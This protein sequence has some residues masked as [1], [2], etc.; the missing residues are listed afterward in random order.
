MRRLLLAVLA[1][2]LA[3]PAS[4]H[5]AE[6]IMA[7]GEVQVG[8]RCTGLTVFRG[9]D[10]SS[11]DVEVL[12]VIG[13]E[14]PASARLLVRVSGPAIDG[15]GVGPGFSGSPILCPGADGVARTIGAISETIGEFGG[16][17]VLA[18][19]IESILSQPPLPESAQP[20]IPGARSLA[21]PLTIAGL[22][23][24]LATS[25]SRAASKAGRVLISSP[26]APR[27]VFDARPLVPGSAATVGITSGDISIGA[28]GTVAYTDGPAVWLFGHQFDAAGR[29]SLFL[30]DAF[31]HAVINNPVAVPDVST[32]K[33]SSPGH[34]LG[35][36]TS[37]GPTAV[38]GIQ[39]ELPPSFPLRVTGRD[40]RTG[41]TVANV[42]RIADEGDVG[43]PAGISPLGLAGSAAVAQ[44][45]GE[46]L[47]GSPSRQSGDMCV[48]VTLRELRR[49]LRFCNTYAV[50]GQ[51]PNAFA[52]AAT[53]DMASATGILDAFKFGT[54]HPT[55]VEVGIRAR[56]GIDQAFITGATAPATVRR[57]SRLRVRLRL[58]HTR[59]GLRSART[60]LVPIPA[61]TPRGERTVRLVGTPADVGG[62]PEDPGDLSIVFEEE[63]TGDDPGV[64]SLA[65]LRSSFES[66][67]R[68]DGVTA[69]FAGERHEVFRDPRLR[70]TGTERL[71][72]RVRP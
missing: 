51:V 48:K 11:F 12:D 70:I 26:A 22:R 5:A 61:S 1:A 56:P 71:S 19:P 16:R 28:V 37:D 9:I 18:T 49:P 58:R 41:R 43:R 34:D 42:T 23:P 64:Q 55:A 53:A 27:A 65:E 44:V 13:A 59:T 57:G 29:R 38:V 7:L 69:V 60:I 62:N 47:A 3:A 66:I 72:V 24:A 35:A 20:V 21:G 30:Q 40:S 31:I 45:A 10:V 50:E 4:A 63:E 67:G 52:G 6:P 32:Y 54:L 14:R 25:F 2:A 68:F 15:T 39:G 33:L 17:T 36:I 46:I 8:A